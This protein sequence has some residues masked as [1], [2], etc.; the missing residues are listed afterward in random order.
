MLH[1]SINSGKAQ[2]REYYCH[3]RSDLFRSLP[4]KDL[5]QEQR[6]SYE[7]FLYQSLPKLLQ[8]Y[9]PVQ[10]KDYNNQIRLEI[11]DSRWE[12]PKFSETEVYRKKITWNQKFVLTWL[13]KWHCEKIQLPINQE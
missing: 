4:Q 8:F 12:E 7:Y 5:A 1:R 13:I 2:R 9:F 11:L 6:E 10:F 3:N